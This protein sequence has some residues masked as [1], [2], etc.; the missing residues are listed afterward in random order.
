MD[1]KLTERLLQL[2]ERLALP[3]SHDEAAY[4]WTTQSKAAIGKYFQSKLAELEKG[5]STADFGLVRGLDAW[6]IAGGSLYDDALRVN[7]SFRE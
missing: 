5:S 4:G 6:G 7:A 1:P 2:I 3:V